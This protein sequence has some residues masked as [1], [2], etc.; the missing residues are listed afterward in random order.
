MKYINIL[1]LWLLVCYNAY[2]Q[3]LTP[4]DWQYKFSETEVTIGDTVDL[5][6][7]VALDE[8][9]Y[10]YANDFDPELGPRPAEFE[11]IPNESYQPIGQ[12]KAIGAIQKYDSLWGGEVSYFEGAAEFRQSIRI[13]KKGLQVKGRYIYQVCTNVDGKCIPGSG[14]FHFPAIKISLGQ[15][16]EGDL[17]VQKGRSLIGDTLLENVNKKTTQEPS[18]MPDDKIVPYAVKQSKLTGS[19][20]GGLWRFAFLA[21]LAGLAAMFTPC[22]F[23]MVP[24]T[25][26]FFSHS[27]NGKGHGKG[28]KK[29]M[30]FGFFIIIIYTFAGTIVSW[31]NGPAFANWLSTHWLPN[32]F[33]FAVFLTFAFSFL[34]MFE[35]TLPSGL[36]NAVDRK[37]DK[38][39]AG[40]VFFMAFTLVLV[41]FS[42]TGPIVGALLVASAGGEI[43]KPVI[44]M[45]SFALALAMPFTLFSAFPRWMERLPKSGGWLNSVKVVLG[46]LELAMGL[47]FLSVA[48]QV[49]HW[50]ILDREVYLA[51]WIVIFSML[52]CYLLGKIKLPHDEMKA[53]EVG[54]VGVPRLLLAVCS[55]AFVVYM[56]PGMWGAPLKAI[57]GYLPPLATHDFNLLVREVNQDGYAGTFADNSLCDVPK[58]SKKLQ[59]PHGIQ[60]YFELDQA[61]DCAKRQNKPLFIDFTGHGCVNCR[62]MEA[63]VWSDKKVL[64]ILK[65]DFVVVALYVDDKEE[66]PE[67]A[68]YRS[69]FDGKIKNTM[70]AQ[71]S[72]YQ[73]TKFN[74]NAQPYYVILDPFTEDPLTSPF[75]YD[76]KVAHFKK[77]LEEG[78]KAFLEDT[79]KGK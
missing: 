39:G 13:L 29:P 20:D 25:V 36:V 33:F 61:I 65:Q 52:G 24:M 45:A 48:D 32:V 59:L 57:A 28:W 7:N 58:Y 72:D 79:R 67:K 68:W 15:M 6:F 22:V 14:T 51:L 38:T 73:I 60:G 47:K 4:A 63:R 26:T 76:L 64:Q 34:G 23:P 2:P 1:F 44:G 77:F 43:I 37:A 55:F 19:T 62:E 8:S 74:N 40:G 31:I 42:C 11:F 17:V 66:L 12:T 3:V 78:K 53:S 16:S 69:V 18:E 75:A 56:L 5:V 9:W 21:F 27:H 41:S 49:Y 54:R 71:N 46:F 50:G 10:L 35:I 30:L 70:G